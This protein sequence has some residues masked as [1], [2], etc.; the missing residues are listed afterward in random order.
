MEN[1][2]YLNI[3]VTTDS[4]EEV[5]EK[6]SRVVASVYINNVSRAITVIDNTQLL[7]NA[8]AGLFAGV[9]LTDLGGYLHETKELIRC[10]PK[11]S[12]DDIKNAFIVCIED[13]NKTRE[14]NVKLVVK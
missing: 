3:H 6:D 7:F 12:E 10:N 2:I 8:S 9:D 4:N 11:Y 5:T 14:D 1:H 13:Y